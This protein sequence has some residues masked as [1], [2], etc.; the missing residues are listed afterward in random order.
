MTSLK[1]VTRPGGCIFLQGY[2][3]KQLDYKTGGPSAVEN[4]YTP[5]ILEE[6]FADWEIDEL[7][8]YEDEI[9]EGLGHKGRSALIGMIARKPDTAN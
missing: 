6:L 3:P 8:E 4:L 2:T 5:K 7:V 9:D 1:W